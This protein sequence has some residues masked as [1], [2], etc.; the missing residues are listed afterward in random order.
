MTDLQ[1]L[2]ARLEAAQ[3]ADR[4]LDAALYCALLAPDCKASISRP[5]FVAITDDDP[6]RWRYNEAQHY[7][8]SIDAALALVERALPGAWW[9]LRHAGGA[10]PSGFAIAE[11]YRPEW[12]YDASGPTPAIAL[13]IA[14]VRAKIAEASTPAPTDGQPKE[15]G[16]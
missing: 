6:S 1:E 11:L 4:V 8:A 15:D 3:E 5:G 12:R 7:T 16:R 10:P 9:T 13:L 14:L 2:L